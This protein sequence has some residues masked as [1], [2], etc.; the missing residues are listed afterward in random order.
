MM[1]L[2]IVLAVGAIVAGIVVPRYAEATARYRVNFA[3]R[4]IAADLELA[5]AT[6]RNASG[7]RT[8]TF[9]NDGTYTIDATTDLDRASSTY[10]VRLAA[11][12]YGATR[13]KASFGA[14]GVVIFDGYGTPD[15]DGTVVVEVGSA[16]KTVL[17][18]ST[19]KASVP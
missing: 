8:V 12:P 13:V 2:L 14:D 3:A 16:S 19:G 5:S 17:L 4:R 15:S 18:D 6:A 10:R 7:P 9:E 1:E 11:E